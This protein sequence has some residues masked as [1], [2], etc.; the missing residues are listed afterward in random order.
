MYLKHLSLTNFRN[1]ARLEVDLPA[2]IHLFQGE[3]AQ[4]KTN[5]LEGIYYLATT[6][7]PLASS[8]RQLMHWDADAEVIPHA[9][10]LARFVR[11]GDEHTLETILVKEPPANGDPQ[12]VV[13]KRQILLDGVPRRA[14]D[15]VGRLNVVLFL[16]QD[17]ALVSGAPAE[18]RRYLD[19]TLCQID[20]QY[21]R[22]LS[23]YNRVMT[24]RNA[25]LRQIREG[26]GRPAEL[27]YW[28]EQLATLG[29]YVL[30]RRLEVVHELGRDAGPIQEALTGG[31]E[32]L[33]LEYQSTLAER[34]EGGQGVLLPDSAPAED[35][36]PDALAAVLS[37]ALRRARSEEMVRGV[38][39]VGPHRD[40]V[41]F[42]LNGV[43]A[44]VYGSRGQ[45]RT[46][47]LAL[48][49]AEVGVME[50]Y[51]GEM[52]ILLLDDVLSELDAR[53]SHHLMETISRAQQV[54]ITTTDLRDYRAEFLDAAMLWR[55][56][57]G[58]L[59]LLEGETPA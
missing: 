32:R 50:R 39:V 23:R 4:G 5:L 59:R 38:T 26:H 18:R 35:V 33:V 29:A 21:C 58:T 31:Q 28:D 22:A 15:V 53:R 55:V 48:K 45:Q 44:T 7:S 16:P 47:A 17:I 51:A 13:F 54:L 40:D 27:D 3:N 57:A 43:D 9:S 41:R 42:V 34:S 30:A 25:L 52:P 2:R 56:E 36:A 6:K 49:L 24:Q 8:D 1:Y 12:N 14:L 10:V 11:A 37:D 46:A 20:A 19:L